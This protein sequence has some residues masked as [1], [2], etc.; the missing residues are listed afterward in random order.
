MIRALH[1]KFVLVAAFALVAAACSSGDGNGGSGEA[2]QPPPRQELTVGVTQDQYTTEGGQASLG[3]AAPNTNVFETLMYM[4]PNFEIKPMLAERWEFRSPNTFRFFLRHGVKFHDGQPLNAQAVKV[5]VFDRAAAA[6]GLTLKAGPESTV[7]VD[8]YTL[9]FTPKIANLRVFEQIVHASYPVIAPGSDVGKKPV[10]TGPFR[11]VEYV[12]K[13]RIVVERNPDYWGPRPSLDK[14]SFRFYP[15]S[16]ARRLALEAGEID[17]AFDLPRAD[18]K[19]LKAAGVN[20]PTSPVGGYEV[21]FADLTG[22][23]PYDLLADTNLRKAVSY[24]IDRKAMITGV[25]DDL[26]TPDQSMVPPA[27]LGPYASVVKGI[28]YDPGQARRILDE[29]GW[30]VGSGGTREKDGRQL[31]LVLVSGYPSAEVLR[32]VPAFVQAQLKAVGIDVTIDERPDSAS[33]R[34]RIRLKEG[35]LFLEQRSQNDADPSFLP[36]VF[37]SDIAE[38]GAAPYQAAFNPGPAFNGLLR[39]TLTEANLDKVQSSVAQA[40]RI[41]V[42]EQATV[43]ALA[44]VYPIYGVRSSV[45]G[46]VGHP[47]TQNV[48]FGTVRIG[49]A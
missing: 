20:V 34:D 40:M 36:A 43:V 16:S 14:L 18:V 47:T 32:P 7:V 28:Q 44:G 37:M 33:F 48:L 17:V 23:A 42:D 5:G 12:P 6:G 26:A 45:Q 49:K 24:A 38:G 13:E 31:K 21:L 2:A 29:A 4:G 39:S 30:R 15:D 8:E 22:K 25:L 9:D 35:D 46:F 11:F 10:G 27:S 41:A 19:S 3:V 1:R